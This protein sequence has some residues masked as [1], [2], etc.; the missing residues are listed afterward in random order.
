M[1]SRCMFA[2]MTSTK[3]TLL[4]AVLTSAFLGLAFMQ[5]AQA[6]TVRSNSSGDLIDEFEA[7]ALYINICTSEIQCCAPNAGLYRFM[8]AST[9][10]NN[11]F[12]CSLD[13]TDPT[14]RTRL[15]I[16]ED[17]YENDC[18]VKYI[19]YQFINDPTATAMQYAIGLKELE[20]KGVWEWEH[21][22]SNA[23]QAAGFQHWDPASPSGTEDSHCAVLNVGG[24]G[25]PL[26]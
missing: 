10:T 8:L 4:F 26:S 11:D 20:Y 5:L 15:A 2:I 13:S 12:L 14:K 6:A 25:T 17:Q 16:I 23:A 3:T 1:G 7:K 19:N 21:A 9:V 24:T 22:P 18:I